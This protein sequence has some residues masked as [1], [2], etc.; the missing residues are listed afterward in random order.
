MSGFSEG[1]VIDLPP[2]ELLARLK[3]HRI[4]AEVPA[5]E[6]AWIAARG[7]LLRFEK[8]AS[9]TARDQ[10]VERLM[11]VLSGN[12][13]IFVDRGEGKHKMAEWRAGDVTGLLPYSRLKNPPGDT[14]AVE[15]TEALSVSGEHL[16]EMI[17]HCPQLT[18]RLVHVMLDRARLFTSNDLHDEKM[19]SLGKLA[20][21]LA[22]ELNN[23]ASAVVRSAKLLEEGLVDAEAAARELGAA[24]LTEAQ[25]EAVDEVRNSCLAARAA[26]SLSPL[27]AADRVD[28]ITDWLEAH[29]AE[30]AIA[31]PLADTAVT[32]PALDRLAKALEGRVLDLALHWV[33]HGCAARSLAKEIETSASRI[34]DLVSAVKGFTHMDQ[35]TT[36]QAV[37]IGQDL[38]ATLMM[39]KA[40]AKAR[41]ASVGV[42]V[43]P[44]L[45]EVPA[46]GGELNQVWVNLID[47]ALDAVAP[48]GRVD[49]S[50]KAEAGKVVVR[51]AD[52]GPGIP[53]SVLPRIFDP[54]FTTKPVGQGT[55][56]GL[57]I[58][59][60]LLNRHNADIQV[61]SHPGR[62]V[63]TVTLPTAAGK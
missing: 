28:S 62:T 23:P 8:G 42:S 32:L 15:S 59:R 22:H 47:N 39:L 11:F 43:D 45:P 63:F 58:V 48:G 35:E 1:T 5:E 61:D 27:E 57:D 2:G 21:G 49:V 54:F 50:A 30:A 31:G 44:G 36:A 19:K 14:L 41:S 13:A 20:A 56:L 38:A 3:G 26:G 33:A 40:K 34:Y 18:T 55:G 29:G 24:Q 46:Y 12:M 10:P 53:D 25:R 4:L 17:R 37:D 52:N 7:T 16:P 6:L 60:R 51:V 9:L